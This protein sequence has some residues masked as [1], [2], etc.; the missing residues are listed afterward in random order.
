[1]LYLHW[2]STPFSSFYYASVCTDQNLLYPN[3]PHDFPTFR[4]FTIIA[5]SCQGTIA[6]Q[7]LTLTLVLCLSA[8]L[9]I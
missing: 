4:V 6:T 7:A 5:E 1:M 8:Y 9:S 3:K 2:E